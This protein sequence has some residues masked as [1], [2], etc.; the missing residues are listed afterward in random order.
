MKSSKI[1]PGT[2]V[3]IAVGAL[4]VGVAATFYLNSGQR[5]A[6]PVATAKPALTVA[7]ALPQ[8]LELPVTLSANGSIAAWQEAVIGSESN[9][10]R[11]L[12]VRVNVGDKVKTGDVLAVFST[13]ST[14]ADTVQARANLLEAQATA[15]DAA[16][17][18][19]RA[20][21]L[22]SSGALSAQQIRQYNTA[23]QTAQARVEAAKAMLDAQQ[24]RGRQTQVL[25]PDNGV[26]SARN[27][28][29]GA[30]V[31]AGS[32]LFRMIRGGRLEWRAE[33]TSAELGR[34]PIG[35]PVQLVTAS[36]AKLT[37]KVR[38]I[39]P[40][41]DPLTRI[42]LVYVDLPLAASAI[43]AGMFASGTFELNQVSALTVP[44]SA[45][46]VRDGFSYLFSVKPDQ[47]ISQLKVQTGRLAGERVE[48]TSG[49]SADTRVV[50]K[51]AGF[52]NDGDLVRVN[53]DSEPNQAVTPALS[54]S[55][56]SK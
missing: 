40:T 56:A 2:L 24:L 25:A 3:L 47:R 12:Q 9:G 35:T 43:Q 52:L 46:V 7:T 4:L 45:L 8:Q 53:D 48:I 20:R 15:L 16:D 39:A 22:D 42:G 6:A 19:A 23:E 18:A 1:K 29:V 10:L 37:G 34:L 5:T 49:L 50:V 14:Q 36:G 41:V 38:M 32:E 33:V 31:G 27:A 55:A 51:G 17:T 13:D 26:I 44:Q 54:A 28:T 30:V 21:T 11:L